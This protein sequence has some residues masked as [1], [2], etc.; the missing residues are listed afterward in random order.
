MRPDEDLIAPQLVE[1]VLAKLGFSDRPPANLSGLQAVY[2]AWCRRVPFD[3]VQKLIR[4][5]ANAPGPLPGDS[6]VDFFK[7]WLAHGTGGTCW[8]GNGALHALLVSL[9]FAS[10]RGL[11]TMLLA[12]DTPPNH[13]TVLVSLEGRRYV[14]DASILH[15]EPLVLDETRPT[16]ASEPAWGVRC[17]RQGA[18]W[19]IDWRPLNIPEGLQA[20]IERL[21]TTR[22]TFQQLHEETRAWS[23]FNYELY[24]RSNRE[25]RVIGVAFGERVELRAGGVFA[26]EP[27][28]K[29]E[30]IRVLVEELGIDEATAARVPQDRERPPPPGSRSAQVG[31]RLS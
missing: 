19:Y 13:G 6:A 14:V 4:L 10:T 24:A 8:A 20:R 7:T 1:A 5:A 18:H 2:G 30:R 23:P 3:N 29:D 12:P 28:G 27:L 15:G 26:R 21:A 16:G 31:K 9:G 25:D 11:G 22:E 17:E